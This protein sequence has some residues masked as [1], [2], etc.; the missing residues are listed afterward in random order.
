RLIR[1]ARESL[2]ACNAANLARC[3]GALFDLHHARG[4][5]LTQRRD[6][7]E[8]HAGSANPSQLVATIPQERM[9]SG[10]VITGCEPAYTRAAGIEHVRGHRTGTR[11]LE[12]E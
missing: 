12:L 10:V 8:V 1:R 5:N 9:E 3:A 6:P 7:H 4:E 11:Q 2:R